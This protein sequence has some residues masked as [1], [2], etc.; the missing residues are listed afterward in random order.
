[1]KKMINLLWLLAALVLVSSTSAFANGNDEARESVVQKLTQAYCPTAV[2]QLKITPIDGGYLEVTGPGGSER[3]HLSDEL[4]AKLQDYAGNPKAGV[5]L[6]DICPTQALQLQKVWG[7]NITKLTADGK[8]K[9]V[10]PCPNVKNVRTGRSIT[11]PGGCQ[12]FVPDDLGSA[13]HY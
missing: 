10:G 7:C 8:K 1:M 11:L 3:I 13:A 4:L 5:Q 6:M 9:S 2:G 12:G